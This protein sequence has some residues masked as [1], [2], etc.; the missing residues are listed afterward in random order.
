MIE[1]FEVITDVAEIAKLNA[2]L[3]RNLSKSFKFKEMREITWPVG[4]ATRN[5]YFGRPIGTSVPAWFHEAEDDRL[6]NYI[7]IGDPRSSAWLEIT[8]QINFPAGKYTRA[9]AGAF[10]RDSTGDVLLSHRG[11]LTKGRAGL[12]KDDVFREF[13]PFLIEAAD[14]TITS[15]LILI[16]SLD[17]PEL[18]ARLLDFAME[19]RE[20]ARRLGGSTNPLVDG[21]IAKTDINR[22]EGAKQPH[23]QPASPTSAE[24]KLKLRNYFDEHAGS[25]D[26]KGRRSGKRTVEHGDIVKALEKLV[27][28]L[29]ATQKSQAIDLALITNNNALLFEVKTSA[30]TTDVYTGVGQLLIHGESIAEL[31]DLPVK[32]FLVLPEKPNSEHERHI[33]T[34]GRMAIVLY[35]KHGNG[36]QF[37][38]L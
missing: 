23:S 26:I 35:S 9:F 4:H 33:V 21:S 7:L 25:S 27:S 29:G 14:N 24:R 16:G 2:K 13:A 11:K 1:N 18:A 5:V 37:D 19:A 28:N 34:K 6:Y 32:R 17:D 36:Y 38:G 10:V 30:R 22:A 15:T 20:V 31:L 3:G 12:K 8:A